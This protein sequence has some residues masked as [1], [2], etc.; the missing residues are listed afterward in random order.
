MSEERLQEIKDSIKAQYDI[1]EINENYIHAKF[2][3]DEEQELVEEIERLNKIIEWQQNKIAK[4]TSENVCL[5]AKIELY[6]D[7]YILDKDSD[8]E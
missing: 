6:E 8:K 7:G 3:T 1:I 2:L 4:L 5:E